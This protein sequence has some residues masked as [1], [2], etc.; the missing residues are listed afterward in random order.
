MQDQAVQW[1][2]RSTFCDPSGLATL[3][4][5]YF[6]AVFL[7][8]CRKL[9]GAWRVVRPFQRRLPDNAIDYNGL[10][11]RSSQAIGRW[12][13]LS[14]LLWGIYVCLI[15]GKVARNSILEP[16]M[17]QFIRC[18]VQEIFVVCNLMLVVVTFAFLARW[19]IEKRL[20]RAPANQLQ[21]SEGIV[22]NRNAPASHHGGQAEGGGYKERARLA[23]ATSTKNSRSLPVSLMPGRDSTPLATSTA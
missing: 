6:L 10:L 9:F 21:A 2:L 8:I 13:Q 7:V 3:L 12:I 14:F 5:F 1:D 15:V 16:S 4:I 22:R 19:H 20:E 11:H 23:R 18:P 17:H